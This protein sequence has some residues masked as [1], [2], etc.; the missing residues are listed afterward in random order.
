MTKC[1]TVNVKLSKSQLSKLK[2]R[3]KNGTEVNLILSSNVTRDSND[4]TD[5]PHKL[6]FADTQVPRLRKAFG[7][8]SSANI[9]LSKTHLS[10]IGQSRGFLVRLLEQLLKTGLSLMKNVPK[11]LAKSALITLGLTVSASARDAAIQKKVL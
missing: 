9:K 4:D 8:V 11:P 10:K 1:S 5:F 3:I 2:S 6:L 7:N